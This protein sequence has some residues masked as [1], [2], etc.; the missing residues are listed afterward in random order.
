M[1]I[2][3][4][5]KTRLGFDDPAVFDELLPIFAKHSLDLLTV[6]GRTVKEMYRSAVHYDFIARAAAELSCPVAGE[7]KR[8]FGGEG[9]PKCSRSRARAV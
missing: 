7:W 5:V 3:F 8:V 4:T 1:K 2:S 6:H 9:V